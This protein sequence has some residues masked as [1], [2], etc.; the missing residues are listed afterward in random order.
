MR[1][2]LIALWLLSTRPLSAQVVFS[3]GYEPLV[4]A[5]VTALDIRDPHLFV[6]V[7][8][9]LCSDVTATFNEEINNRIAGDDDG[10]GLLDLNLLNRFY[11]DRMD[12]LSARVL[13]VES[14][15]AVCSAPQTGTQCSETGPAATPTVSTPMPTGTCLQ[16]LAGTTGGYTP[17]VA[18][19]P[20][21]C[22]VSDA[23]DL[24]LDL[25]GFE[26]PLQ[27]LQSAARHLGGSDLDA[28]L[29]RGFLSES[30]AENVLL[31][32]DLPLVGGLPLS[33]L[34]PGGSGNC[35]GN[36]DRD[37]GPDGVT[38]GWWF[39]LNHES[40]RVTLN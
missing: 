31:P 40:T 37:I 38:S 33:A 15:Q 8:D 6:L 11:T 17:P 32:A 36:D 35:S 28:G 9:V 27:G 24:V 12:D 21:P 14:L 22:Q 2:V 18:D 5:R 34:L 26:L 13:Q 39:Y 19:T 30:D 3:N 4:T 16:P 23:Q 29:M 1:F 20:A 25:D 7:L 10:D